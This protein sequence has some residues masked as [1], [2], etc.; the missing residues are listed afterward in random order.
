MPGSLCGFAPSSAKDAD[1]IESRVLTISK[2]YVTNTEV[3]PAKPPQMSRLKEVRPDPGY[4]SNICCTLV[5]THAEL[6]GLSDHNI[7]FLVKV[8]RAE[9]DGG[10]RHYAN[11]IRT[12]SAHESSPT[13]FAPHLHQALAD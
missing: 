9:L 6:K 2:G 7:H 10:V 1:C 5:S 12:I 4:S 8:E 3:T 13:F 11:A